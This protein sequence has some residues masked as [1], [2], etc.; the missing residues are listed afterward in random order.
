MWAGRGAPPAQQAWSSRP[1]KEVKQVHKRHIKAVDDLDSW[2][3]YDHVSLTAS[4]AANNILLVLVPRPVVLLC[5]NL[6]ASVSHIGCRALDPAGEGRPGLPAPMGQ[7]RS[8]GRRFSDREDRGRNHNKAIISAGYV[9]EGD[10]GIYRRHRGV[11]AG[12]MLQSPCLPMRL[13]PSLLQSISRAIAFHLQDK[14]AESA[15]GSVYRCF[16]PEDNRFFALRHV[17]CS[18]EQRKHLVANAVLTMEEAPLEGVAPLLGIYRDKE[19]GDLCLLYPFYEARSVADLLEVTPAPPS[20]GPLD[21][22]PPSPLSGPGST[23]LQAVHLDEAESAAAGG[24]LGDAASE[25]GG[26]PKASFDS[27]A[28]WTSVPMARLESGSGAGG[29]GEGR[30][31]KGLEESMVV[32]IIADVLQGLLSIHGSGQAHRSL[33]ARSVLLDA[34]S[35]RAVIAGRG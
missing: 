22:S 18:K 23:R 32:G 19:T 17:R 7:S 6:N 35:G 34:D 26:P 12:S 27:G 14:I 15:T 8:W 13:P 5:P 33:C 31:G 30:G 28:K 24:A 11:T 3:S 2:I 16:L 29:A 9:S 20:R 10:R 4:S 21:S 1:F 25:K